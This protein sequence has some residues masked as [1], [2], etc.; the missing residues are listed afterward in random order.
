MRTATVIKANDSEEGAQ[1]TFTLDSVTVG[2]DQEGNPTTAPIVL[3]AE[4]S[5]QIATEGPRLTKNQQTMFWLLQGAGAAGLTTEQWNE[6]ARAVDIGNDI[7]AAL[8]SK[9][10]VRQYGDRWNVA[11][12]LVADHKEKARPG[13]GGRA[14]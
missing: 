9:E 14:S 7:R 11:S 13:L 1:I 6:R 2:T 5:A 10:I 4:A 3:P 8:K 12:G